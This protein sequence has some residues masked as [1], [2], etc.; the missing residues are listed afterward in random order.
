VKAIALAGLI[1]FLVAKARRAA[2]AAD[3]GESPSDDAPLGAATGHPLA[4]IA[5]FDQ[6][7]AP[8]QPDDYSPF[9]TP[10]VE[11][12]GSTINAQEQGFD[13]INP[14]EITPSRYAAAQNAESTVISNI[15]GAFRQQYTDVRRLANF[16][17]RL[18][19]RIFG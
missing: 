19:H 8:Q 1:L 9:Y 7:A 6:P 17:I 2:A 18:F 15:P 10:I 16:H 14:Q 11:Q 12:L 13:L 5:F 4:P 3:D